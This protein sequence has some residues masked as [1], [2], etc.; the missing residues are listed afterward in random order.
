M[1]P[2]WSGW[3]LA[4]TTADGSPPVTDGAMIVLLADTPG[5]VM[6]AMPT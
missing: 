2:D 1:Q 4:S 3:A 6:L 5:T